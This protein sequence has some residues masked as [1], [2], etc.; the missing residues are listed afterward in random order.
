M[1]GVGD[2]PLAPHLNVRPTAHETGDDRVRFA[3]QMRRVLLACALFFL[4][5]TPAQAETLHYKFGPIHI[6]PGQNDIDL[7]RSTISA[8]R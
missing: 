4:F 1:D 3:G 8:R 7:R 2:P 5:A 6:A